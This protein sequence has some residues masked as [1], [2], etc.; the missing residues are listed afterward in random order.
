MKFQVHSI[1]TRMIASVFLTA[2]LIVIGMGFTLSGVQKVSNGFM[3]YLSHNQPRLD[4]LNT[5]FKDGLLGGIAAR[6]KIFNP[7]L[8]QPAQVIARAEESFER[9]LEAAREG[10]PGEQQDVLASLNQI[11]QQ[12]SIV[13]GARQEVLGLMEQGR[14]LEASEILA[15]R[16]NPAWRAIRLELEQL[17]AAEQERTLLA[18]DLVQ[19]QVDQTFLHGLA[20]GL[21]AIGAAIGL[22]LWL[23]VT[24]LRRIDL[25]RVL[26]DDLSAGEGDLTRRLRLGGRDEIA[27]VASSFNTFLEK[28][29][30]LVREVMDSTSQVASAAEELAAVTR[31]SRSAVDRQLSETD[32]VATAMNEMTATVQEVAR[33]ALAASN[34]AEDANE[35]SGRGAA[36][37]ETTRATIERLATEVERAAAAMETVAND[38]ERIGTVLDVIKNVSEQ[39]NLL[40]LNAAIEAARAGEQGRGFAVVAD[41][42]R[43]LASRT[44]QST[45]EIETMVEQL[46]N[47]TCNALQV[48]QESRLQAAESVNS[49]SEAHDAL[50]RI[51]SAVAV[52]SDMNTQIASAAEEQSAV[53]EEINRNI[54]NINDVTAQVG[55]AS[56]QTYIAS[57]E[58]A[59]L[60]EQLQGLVRQFRV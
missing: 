30:R 49:A 48:M 42:V 46:Q 39:T 20:V 19:Q 54:T 14:G 16:E 32:Q 35:E 11:E 25:I 58:L 38:S 55:S 41:E 45:A 31:E 60:A 5:M 37:V 15:R 7:A 47:G 21:I 17:V 1:R 12:W 44:Q 28:V 50:G 26:I 9:A 24:V 10:I 40:A 3:Q 56:E 27:A 57:E 4:A 29:H 36:V 59:R 34:A 2:A 53:A 52:I 13:K 8:P 23:G 33:N 22:S 6:N 43:M 18:R 51:T